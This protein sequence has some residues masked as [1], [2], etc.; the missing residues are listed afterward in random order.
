MA[1]TARS[2]A[3]RSEPVNCS[4]MVGSNTAGPQRG[5]ARMPK[6]SAASNAPAGLGAKP[7]ARSP[8][9]V[10]GPSEAEYGRRT[11]WKSAH[12]QPSTSTFLLESAG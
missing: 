2:N 6:C 12:R 4:A 11:P 1:R 3:C 10:R 9:T 5:L 8:T 7:Y